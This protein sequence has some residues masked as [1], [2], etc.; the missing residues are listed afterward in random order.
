[1]N[2]LPWGNQQI[3]STLFSS[4]R[5]SIKRCGKILESSISSSSASLLSSLLMVPKD[6]LGDNS[7]Q[8]LGRFL[9][10]FVGCERP[11]SCSLIF[12]KFNVREV[13][14]AESSFIAK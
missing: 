7:I 2:A 6:Q 13:F 4:P 5:T 14:G 12:V 10:F 9:S 1:M 11:I 3:A 8:S